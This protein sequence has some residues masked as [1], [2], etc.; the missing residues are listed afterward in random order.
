MP[1]GDKPFMPGKK[2]SIVPGPNGVVKKKLI[3]VAIERYLLS[4]VIPRISGFDRWA[5]KYYTIRVDEHGRT[6]I[7][8]DQTNMAV[9]TYGDP[10]NMWFEYNVSNFWNR[11]IPEEILGEWRVGTSSRWKDV[12]GGGW[13]GE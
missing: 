10:T 4:Y 8:D 5:L 9:M 2:D 6:Q 1:Y 13:S 3:E 7:I 12:P 11:F